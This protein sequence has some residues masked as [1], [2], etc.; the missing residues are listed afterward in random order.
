MCDRQA[1][2]VLGRCVAALFDL[3]EAYEQAG[4]VAHGFPMVATFPVAVGARR[5][6]YEA[7]LDVLVGADSVRCDTEPF[8]HLR[9]IPRALGAAY[10]LAVARHAALCL[11]VAEATGVLTPVRPAC[12][13]RRRRAYDALKLCVL[14]NVS[15][16]V[17]E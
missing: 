7:R 2:G 10:V 6:G 4:V 17:I 13:A 12:V 14:F 5:D 1:W 15:N 16:Q 3:A 11:L 8:A 9:L